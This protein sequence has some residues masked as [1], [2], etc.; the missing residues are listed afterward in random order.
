MKWYTIHWCQQKS[1]TW[2]LY[3]QSGKFLKVSTRNK[4][5]RLNSLVKPW[6]WLAIHL[7]ETLNQWRQT[8]MFQNCHITASDAT[9][10]H[11]MFAPNLLGTR[12]EILRHNLDRVVMD[13]VAVPK[14]FITLH[15]FVSLVA[16]V[17]FVNG[18]P[19]LI[20]MIPGIKFVTVKHIPTR[21]DKRLSKSLR[22][23]S[24]KYQPK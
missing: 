4:S 15:N 23:R 17:M 22:P 24:A 18:A 2:H 9:N 7:G 21:T 10:A 19:F 14:D 6:E 5:P 3:K 20:T 8:I 11:T 16:A 13:Y 12:G 1:R